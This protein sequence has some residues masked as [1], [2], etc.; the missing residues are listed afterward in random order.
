MMELF[1]VFRNVWVEVGYW[2]LNCLV[3]QFCN[4]AMIGVYVSIIV[5]RIRKI[6]DRE[7]S[8]LEAS[9]YKINGTGVVGIIRN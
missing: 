3:N 8:I 4:I 1:E 6:R 9:W 5:G 2:C 7:S